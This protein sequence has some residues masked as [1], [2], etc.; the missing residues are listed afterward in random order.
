M[1]ARKRIFR[2]ILGGEEVL[3]LDGPGLVSGK[4]KHLDTRLDFPDWFKEMGNH[5]GKKVI[6]NGKEY[7]LVGMM[8]TFFDYYYLVEDNEGKQR[9]ISCVGNLKIKEDS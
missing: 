3:I 5:F 1:D 6:Y 9:G 7:T 4:I 8:Y 2:N